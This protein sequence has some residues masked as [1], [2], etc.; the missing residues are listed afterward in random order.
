M[1]DHRFFL[2]EQFQKNYQVYLEDAELH[3][4][5]HV[6]RVK[7]G[8]VVEIINGKG[9]LAQAVV[10]RF[11]KHKA[12]L[13]ITQLSSEPLPSHK[14]ILAQAIPRFPRLEYILEKATELGVTEFWLFP[15]VGSEKKDFS[16]SQWQRM[17]QILISALKQSGRLHMPSLE[18]KP[19][20]DVWPKPSM[21]GFYGSTDP[22]APPFSRLLSQGL[23]KDYLFVIGPEKGLT[24]GEI[25]LCETYSLKGVSLN[26]NILRVDTAAI[27]AISILSSFILVK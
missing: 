7:E 11:E 8:E 9:D 27:S 12:S 19:P 6:M 17:H 3:H 10:K 22:K 4:L 21:S 23:S 2:E 14:L 20:L 18:I 25:S 15:T 16:P 13:E 26:P 24:Q 5:Q 1:P